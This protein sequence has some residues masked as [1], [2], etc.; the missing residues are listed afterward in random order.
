MTTINIISR[1]HAHTEQTLSGSPSAQRSLSLS[2]KKINRDMLR[3]FYRPNH[4]LICNSILEREREKYV[5]MFLATDILRQR[6]AFT[7]VWLPI[8]PDKG[9]TCTCFLYLS[10]PSR[11][12]MHK[13]LKAA[14]IP[15]QRNTFVMLLICPDKEI[16]VLF[17]RYA[18]TRKFLCLP[19][20]PDREILVSTDMPR[21]GNSCVYRYAQTRK[22][23][24]L[25]ICPEK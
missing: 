9:N 19:V 11:K 8:C 10:A 1:I 20:C 14:H 24:C 15:R 5:Y 22:F 17:Y 3:M 23:L 4:C 12:C 2:E 6:N 21:Q 13:C 18:Q 25:P 16:H 7:C